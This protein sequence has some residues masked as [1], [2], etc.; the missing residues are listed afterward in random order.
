MFR[1]LDI[2][3]GEELLATCP[4]PKLDDHPLPPVYDS[5]FNTSTATLHIGGRSSNHNLMTCQVVVTGTH[6]SCIRYLNL[7]LS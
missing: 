3:Y 7:L 6:L 2:V 4:N 1:N 5:L